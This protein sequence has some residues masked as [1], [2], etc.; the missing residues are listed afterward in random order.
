MYSPGRIF[1]M[2]VDVKKQQKLFRNSSITAAPRHLPIPPSRLRR[3]T[4]LFPSGKRR[5]LGSATSYGCA[6]FQKGAVKEQQKFFHSPR[7]S[8]KD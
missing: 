4:S 3:A 1:Y 2:V 5:L 6:A 7:K 8:R